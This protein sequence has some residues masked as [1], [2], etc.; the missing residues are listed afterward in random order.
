MS[1]S[2]PV[3]PRVTL[4]ADMLAVIDAASLCFAA[5]VT[6]DGRPNLSPKGTIRVWD[7]RHLFFLDIASPRTR[8]NLRHTPWMELNVVDLLSRRG[9]RFT[10]AAL[11]HDPGSEVFTEAMHRV[12]GDAPPT[13]PVATVVVLE[14]AEAAPLLS[15]AYWRVAD[16]NELRATWRS[17][18]AALDLDFD[19]HV[20]RVGPVTVDRS[21]PR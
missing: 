20:A 21:I 5:T 3:T 11:V 18:R 6:P 16:E 12:F 7:D 17:R 19:E 2:E 4:T 10:G 14:I 9:Y 1:Q 8:A 15:P 13:Y